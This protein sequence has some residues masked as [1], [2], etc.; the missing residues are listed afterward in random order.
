MIIYKVL[1]LWIIF[2]IY[3]YIWEIHKPC[4]NDNLD[5]KSTFHLTTLNSGNT[6]KIIIVL[7][8]K[9]SCI[10]SLHTL[11]ILISRFSTF[12]FHNSRDKQVSCFQNST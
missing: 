5:S 8:I 4:R 9:N 10:Y 2:I 12:Q 3:I 6:Y 7:N 11:H 1:R